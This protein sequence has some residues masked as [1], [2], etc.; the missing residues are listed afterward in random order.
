MKKVVYI[1][2]G[3]KHSPK[4]KIYQDVGALFKNKGF[5]VVYVKIDWKFNSFPDWVN[6]FL[7]N[8]FKEDDSKKYLFGFSYGALISLLVSSKKVRKSGIF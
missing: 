8:Y 6:D 5:E 2:P 7:Q 4:Q 3:F 1:I